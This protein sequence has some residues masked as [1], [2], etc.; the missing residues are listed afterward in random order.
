[1]TVPKDYR[2]APARLMAGKP[3]KMTAGKPSKMTAGK[4]LA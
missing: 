4:L 2:K 3:S 1:M